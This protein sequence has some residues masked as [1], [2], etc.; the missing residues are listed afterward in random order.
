MIKRGKTVVESYIQRKVQYYV[1][2]LLPI[3]NKKGEMKKKEVF[4]MIITTIIMITVPYILTVSSLLHINFIK[5]KQKKKA[6]LMIIN[7]LYM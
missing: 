7:L 3:L 1:K 4:I 6:T 5:S 2:C